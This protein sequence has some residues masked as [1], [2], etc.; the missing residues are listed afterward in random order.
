MTSDCEVIFYIPV[1]GKDKQRRK[2]AKHGTRVPEGRA[3][4]EGSYTYVAQRHLATLRIERDK[5]I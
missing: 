4:K 5:V 2:N 3:E 1:S